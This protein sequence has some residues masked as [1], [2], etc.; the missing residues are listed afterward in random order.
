VGAPAGN[1]DVAPTI[2]ALTGVGDGLADDGRVLSEAL[3][4][5]STNKTCP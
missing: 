3:K 5:A 2:L 1:V 4:R